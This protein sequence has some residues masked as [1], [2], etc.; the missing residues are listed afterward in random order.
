MTTKEWILKLASSKNFYDRNRAR[1]FSYFYPD[2][3]ETV[4]L[5]TKAM[6]FLET[7]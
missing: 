1:L 6:D 4:Y 7:L 3:E 5:R 2:L